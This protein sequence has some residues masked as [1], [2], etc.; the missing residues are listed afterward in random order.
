M[1]LVYLG[2]R[3]GSKAESVVAQREVQNVPDEIVASCTW[4]TK[5]G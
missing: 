1:Q 2:G 5:L 3:G 4:T